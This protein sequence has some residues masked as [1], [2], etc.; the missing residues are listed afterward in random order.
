MLLV[1]LLILFVVVWL[2]LS[3]V[4]VV[5]RRRAALEHARWEARARALPEGGHVIELVHPVQ[6]TQTVRRIAGDLDW[7]ALG[8]ELADGMAEAEARAATLNS[9]G[10]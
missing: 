7:D 5:R 9:L 10:R 3:V 6:P 8:T 2:A 1:D 4:Y